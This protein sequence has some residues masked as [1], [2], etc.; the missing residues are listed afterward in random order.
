MKLMTLSAALMSAG[1]LIAMPALA[2]TTQAHKQKTQE[3]GAPAYPIDCS[4]VDNANPTGDP[5]CRQRTQN[6]VP[7]TNMSADKR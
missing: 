6:L 7:T 4:S 2:Q 1:M 3:G 5:N